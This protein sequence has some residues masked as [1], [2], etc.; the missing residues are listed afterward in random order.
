MK[1]LL[2]DTL[3]GYR[4]RSFQSVLELAFKSGKILTI[5]GEE[6]F[7]GGAFLDSD[8]TTGNTDD[9]GWTILNEREG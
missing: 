7:V 3:V 2:G 9:H 1:E 5:A 4:Y 6:A 8:V